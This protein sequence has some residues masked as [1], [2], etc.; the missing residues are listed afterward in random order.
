M[1]TAHIVVPHSPATLGPSFV[2]PSPSM[3]INISRCKEAQSLVMSPRLDDAELLPSAWS[4]L[5]ER[6]MRSTRQLLGI[7]V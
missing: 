6:F 3:R 1:E 2:Q 5:S 7:S 4:R